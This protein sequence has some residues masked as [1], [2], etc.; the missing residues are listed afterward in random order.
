MFL[1]L[2]CFHMPWIIT[3]CYST[4][5]ASNT[6]W[7]TG[8]VLVKVNF[9]RYLHVHLYLLEMFPVNMILKFR[10]TWQCYTNGHGEIKKNII[11]YRTLLLHVSVILQNHKPFSCLGVMHS[12]IILTGFI[13]TLTHIRNSFF[14]TLRVCS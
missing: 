10:V 11:H 13:F 5:R 7:R 8:K 2:V 3:P 9:S 12:I 4:L 14:F 1:K 6:Y